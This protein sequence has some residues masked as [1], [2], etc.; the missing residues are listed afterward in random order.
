MMCTFDETG[1]GRQNCP[2]LEC[3]CCSVLVP[4]RK[5]ETKMPNSFFFSFHF[6]FRAMEESRAAADAIEQYCPLKSNPLNA[7]G[8]PPTSL[9]RVVSC[10]SCQESGA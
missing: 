8:G 7:R 2:H 1:I 10:A 5:E 3:D 6:R 4:G 9:P